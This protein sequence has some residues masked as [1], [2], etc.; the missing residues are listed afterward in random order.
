MARII[1]IIVFISTTLSLCSCDF[2]FGEKSELE[3]EKIALEE[4]LRNIGINELK[5]VSDL[6]E[7]EWDMICISP[8]YIS[9]PY[10]D[11]G[12]DP[13][14]ELDLT[15]DEAHWHFVL[16]REGKALKAFSFNLRIDVQQINF[17]Q[18]QT[19]DFRKLNFHPGYCPAFN[20]AAIFKS[21]RRY[22]IDPERIY[23]YITLGVINQ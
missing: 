8:P 7:G 4:K 1:K 22:P 13:K 6:I 17:A 12:S 15:I 14:D 2:I 10:D 19:D 21:Q 9:P 23:T 18:K 20:Q 11:F 3:K 16:Y 5:K